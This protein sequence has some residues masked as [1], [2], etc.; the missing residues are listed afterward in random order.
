MTR[1]LIGAVF[2]VVLG[3][4]QAVAGPKAKRAAPLK[5][6]Q[7]V[8]AVRA[9]DEA[10]LVKLAR[11]IADGH[12]DGLPPAEKK[13]LQELRARQSTLDG[14]KL[15]S[16][17]AA[18]VAFQ[19]VHGLFFA[20]E[21]A[22]RA[23][24][25]AMVLNTFGAALSREA[26]T[27]EA[28]RVLVYAR[29]LYPG[30][31][32][33]L[34]NLAS[35]AMEI[36]DDTE[37]ERLLREATRLDKAFCGAWNALGGLYLARGKVQE[38]TQAFLSAAPCHPIHLKHRMR[39]KRVDVDN[40]PP[41]PIL[42]PGA[43]L[44]PVTVGK[45]GKALFRTWPRFNDWKHFAGSAELLK[46]WK[47]DLD[48]RSKTASSQ[49]TAMTSKDGMARLKQRYLAQEE[50]KR[51]S[52]YLWV[53]S[54]TDD[55]NWALGVNGAYYESEI[56]KLH[57]RAQERIDAGDK[58]MVDGVNQAQQRLEDALRANGVNPGI[59]KQHRAT[60]CS[61]ANPLVGE[62]FVTWREAR[63]EEYAGV[64]RLLSE[65]IGATDPWIAQIP[66]DLER[67]LVASTRN[68]AIYAQLQAML[69]EIQM[70]PLVFAAPFMVVGDCDAK[71][72]KGPTEIAGL[73]AAEVDEI[74]TPPSGCP[75]KRGVA[76]PLGESVELG[77]KNCEEIELE[78]KKGA[79]GPVGALGSV[80]YHT[81]KKELTLSGGTYLDADVPGLDK[82]GLKAGGTFKSTYSVT[83]RDGKLANIRYTTGY[84]TAAGLKNGPQLKGWDDDVVFTLY[85]APEPKDPGPLKDWSG[86]T[87]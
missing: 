28:L 61:A 69:M 14:L 43:P 20:A 52:P 82:V 16:E 17:A 36:G 35:A 50:R 18:R 2:L 15:S 46:A 85:E 57:A 11:G 54:S 47:D 23:P 7:K 5:G 63:A 80:K 71:E 67:E 78:A 1:R 29:A 40:P 10:G 12:L 44:A 65:W 87:R 27:S 72:K 70:R 21:A 81:R 9:L 4:A 19:N 30:N 76:M 33:I 74:P 24:K 77:M 53:L 51:S 13:Q 79:L 25:H 38:A 59:M 37:A 75:M 8:S 45:A 68:L 60:Y 34:T 64:T 86:A 49:L 41:G 73:E 42:P 26:R 22:A 84:E 62:G 6:Y 56:K 39:L 55:V 83:F 3:A 58:K 66:D 48:R 32:L 31:A